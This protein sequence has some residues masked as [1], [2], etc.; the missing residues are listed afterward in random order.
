MH[1]LD[2]DKKSK[3]AK[4]LLALFLALI[5]SIGVIMPV[6]ANDEEE[7]AEDDEA[8]REAER[9]QLFLTTEYANQDEKL[10]SFGEKTIEFNDG[11]ERN[12][13]WRYE[14]NGEPVF[15]KDGYELYFHVDTGEVAV[16]D[17][18][19]GQVLFS[20]PWDVAEQEVQGSSESTKMNLMS[21]ILIRYREADKQYDFNSFREAAMHRQIKM[22][23]IKG[24]IRVEYT[25]GREQKRMLV[26]RMIEQ[27]SFEGN[28]LEHITNSRDYDKM[29]A[30][31]TLKDANDPDLTERAKKELQVTYP[32]TQRYAIYV[33]DPHASDREIRQIE[34]FIRLYTKYTFEMMDEDHALL[35]YE[36]KDKAPP[37]FKLAL[38][39]YIDE[40]GFYVRLPVNGIRF[41][42]STYRISY[43]RVLPFMGAGRREN[44]GYT[45]VPDGSGALVRYEDIQG[46]SFTSTNRVY[47]NDYSFH[48]ASGGNHTK[49]WR[50]PVYGNVEE[51]EIVRVTEVE[52]LTIYHDESGNR[53]DEPL[54]A[55]DDDG[56]EY[57]VFYDASG[58][59]VQSPARIF[60]DKDG[61]E[62]DAIPEAEIEERRDGF[63][64]IIEDGDVLADISTD[65]GGN[66]HKYNT[67][68][69]QFAPR[70][71]DEFNLDFEMQGLN[72]LITISSR[73]KYT[74]N[75][76]IRY[77]MLSSDENGEPAKAGGYEATYVGMAKAYRDYLISR[78]ELNPMEDDGGDIPL[79]IEALGAVKTAEYFL[80]MPYIGTTPLTSFED[81]KSIVDE[82]NEENI[83][84]IKFKLNGWMN[85]G[86]RSTAPAKIKAERKLGGKDGLTEAA[87]YARQKGAD[88]YPDVDFALVYMFRPFDGVNQRQDRARYLNQL[89]A[90]EQV[91]CIICQEMEPWRGRAYEILATER[92]DQMYDK[93]MKTYDTLNVGAMSVASLGRELHSN[94]WRRSMVSRSEAKTNVTNLFDR[95]YEDHSNLLA[96]SANAYSFRYLDS[97][98]DVDLDSSRMTNQSEPV[99]FYGMV[100][101]GFIN[102]AG[103]PINMSGDMTYDILKAIENG[104]SPY[105][106]L[107]YQN[108][109]RLKEASS[110]SLNSYYSVDYQVWLPD[111]LRIYHTLNDALKDVKAKPIV[112]HEFPE[113]NVVKV[114]YEGGVSFI[115]NYNH[116]DEVTV[117][118]VVVPARDFVRVN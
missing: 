71:M 25:L 42:E 10:A 101:H 53:I 59:E 111:M 87:E 107:G 84:N 11:T 76:I 79:F 116:E 77:I 110:W 50:L 66:M 36:P 60:V 97:I 113:A 44:I 61:N 108:A 43:I 100:T 109:N 40:G 4:R 9:I 45:F 89:Y 63:I 30:Y 72:S 105:F 57:E 81:I 15:S 56:E 46:N 47:G 102:I 91:Y 85:G 118:G 95:M 78:G 65:H 49:T 24:G 94:H 21:Q 68:F 23:R 69:S 8:K 34:G 35:D 22:K 16:K 51:Y 106:V 37:L 55:I 12:P 104:A 48:K 82:L 2:L 92:M 14:P 96:A 38:E 74:G 6:L 3:L 27:S 41:D 114:T 17:T 62:Y 5:M 13:V 33:F 1:R 39:Y 29:K 32:Q 54:T 86:L 75:Y 18:R 83:S 99:P 117:D 64:A 103:S 58:N 19:T 80:G 98:T 70:P 67:V 7:D 28:I 31:Y 88:V 112:G 73:R 115:L 26:P 90:R 20:N 52:P 93:A